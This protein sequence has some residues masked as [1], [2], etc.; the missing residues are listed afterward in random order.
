MISI[1]YRK[2]SSRNVNTQNTKSVKNQGVSR[3]AN[4]FF[5]C[6]KNVQSIVIKERRV[7]IMYKPC[8]KS[9]KDQFI[10]RSRSNWK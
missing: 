1:V 5:I 10:G 4:P 6:T 8:T 2:S 7:R 9:N 3:N